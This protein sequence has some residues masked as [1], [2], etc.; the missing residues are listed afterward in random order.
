VVAGAKNE[1]KYM[2]IV[3]VGPPGAGKGTQAQMLKQ[4]FSIPHISTGDLLRQAV[5]EGTPLGKQARAYMDKGEL[6]PDELV[7][8]MVAERLQHSNC[9]SGFLLDGF[10]RTIM[11]ADALA[12]E[13]SRSEKRLDGVVSIMVPRADLVERLSGRRVCRE[14]GAM[15]HE[16]F[17]PPKRAGVCDKC[18]GVLYQR[19][20]DNAETV[21]ARLSVYERA[22]APLLSYYRDRALL[23]EVDGHGAPEEICRRITATLK[24]AQ[25][26]QGS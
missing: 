13:L 3:L 26:T 11:Q 1:E 21:S 25:A 6:V 16:R 2:R 17:D 20:D 23:Y 15:Y 4:T 10:P 18:Q 14:C 22:T 8:A 24:A 19:S 12:E 5:K 7:T 9:V